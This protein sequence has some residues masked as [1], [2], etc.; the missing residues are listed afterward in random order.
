MKAVDCSELFR[1]FEYNNPV[2]RTELNY[3]SAYE[4][5]VAVILSAQATDASVNKATS[6]LFKVVDS[7]EKMIQL[8]EKGLEKYIRSIGLYRNKARNLILCSQ[9]LVDTYNG[10][11]PR[12][13]EDLESLAGVG[14]KTANVVLNT[15]YGLPF[16]A[17]DTHVF[18]VANRTGLA[19]GNTVVEVERKLEKKV[20]TR[21]LAHAHHWLVLHGRY[22]CK[23]RNPLCE[24]CFINDLC[25]YY[26]QSCA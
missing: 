6:T 14:R 20:P 19:K 17:V 3:C 11:V 16:I 9:R 26:S 1:R 25:D 7:P 22:I 21:Y 12:S 24:K 2:P 5:L 10:Q 15:L 13:R 18:R 23:A 8:G 4:L